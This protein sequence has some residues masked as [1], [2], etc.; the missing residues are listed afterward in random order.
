M[1]NYIRIY[2]NVMSDEKCQYFIDKFE[3]HSEMQEVQNNSQGKTLTMMNL[4][5]SPDT[6][7]KSDLVYLTNLFME[8][9]EKYKKNCNIKSFQFPKEMGVEAFKIKKY[10][11][12][13]TDEFPPHV[14]VDN[15]ATARRFLVM[16]A[17]LDDN[18]E[19]LTELGV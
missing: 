13:T 19:G 8:N 15:Y 17:Y 5:N 18:E 16:F 2:E 4:M 11:P 3:A 14:D 7:F 10:M 6:P 12:N 1:D 9:V